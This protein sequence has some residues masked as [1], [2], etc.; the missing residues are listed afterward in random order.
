VRAMLQEN[1]YIADTDP[2]NFNYNFR[3]HKIEYVY[4]LISGSVRSVSLNAS[5]QDKLIHRYGYD[6]RNRLASVMTSTDGYWFD[7][8]AE[9]DYYYHGPLARVEY[10][11]YKSQGIDYTYTLK[12]WLKAINSEQLDDAVD[13]GGDGNTGMPTRYVA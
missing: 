5:R 13:P 8:D 12:G 11:P 7:T 10:G 1:K 2:S 6:D 9:Y 3:Y 4:D